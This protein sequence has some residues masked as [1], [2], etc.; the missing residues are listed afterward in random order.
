MKVSCIVETNESPC[1]FA[2]SLLRMHTGKVTE[3]QPREL[4]A[5][6]LSHCSNGI[7]AEL[8]DYHQIVLSS[9]L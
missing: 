3:S 2:P 7:V 6:T 1:V 5:A 8:R 4:K 9:A